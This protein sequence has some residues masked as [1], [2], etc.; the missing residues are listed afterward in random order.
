VLLAPSAT[1]GSESVSAWPD[2]THL[3]GFL[4]AAEVI[5][6]VKIGVGVTDSSKVTLERNGETHQA[7]FKV[8]DRHYDSWRREVAAYELDKYLGLGMVPPTVERRIRGR[9]GCLQL[10]VDGEVLESASDDPENLELWRQQVSTMWLI[11]YLT[12]NT[13]R[14]L[15]NALITPESRLVLIDNSRAFKTFTT[16]VMSLAEARS[17]TRAKF[18]MV[19]YDADRVRYSTTYRDALVK[20]L[21]AMTEKDLKKVLGRYIDKNERRWLM[22]RRDLILQQIEELRRQ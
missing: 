7:I 1:H 17:A 12:A 21:S 20:R 2:G 16:G 8:F 14:H 5:D 19:E 3:E 15:N 13:D 4:L 10:W 18:W 22:E 9:Q 6:R 11:D